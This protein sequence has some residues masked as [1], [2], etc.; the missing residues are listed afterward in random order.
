MAVGGPTRTRPEQPED[1]GVGEEVR[2]WLKVWRE[3]GARFQ[4]ED[5]SNTMGWNRHYDV[6]L[7]QILRILYVGGVQ[8]NGRKRNVAHGVSEPIVQCRGHGIQRTKY[9]N[10]R[11]GFTGQIR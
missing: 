6:S 1:E 4:V 2:S 9:V 10:A 11:L 7:V 3:G 8:C 5:A